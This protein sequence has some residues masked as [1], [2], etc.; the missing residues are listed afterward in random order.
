MDNRECVVVV[1]GASSGI[2][3]ACAT[4]LAKKGNKVYG[5]C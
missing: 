3:N 5:T 4:Y 2:G 1:T